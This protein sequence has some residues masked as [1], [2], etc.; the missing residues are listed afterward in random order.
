MPYNTLSSY[1]RWA[2]SIKEHPLFDSEE[3]WWVNYRI[4][5]KTMI[6]MNG[7]DIH[8]FWELL[9]VIRSSPQ[10]NTLQVCAI[11]VLQSE[12]ARMMKTLAGMKH[13]QD[14]SLYADWCNGRHDLDMVVSDIA[15]MDTPWTRLSLSP[16]LG[17]NGL[18]DFVKGLSQNETLRHLELKLDHF[19]VN[20]EE[21]AKGL[22]SLEKVLQKHPSLESTSLEFS[23]GRETPR[24][25][26]YLCDLMARNRRLTKVTVPLR[27]ITEAQLKSLCSSL[28]LPGKPVHHLVLQ[29]SD[30]LSFNYAF[31]IN[32]GLRGNLQIACLTLS[33]V[34]VTLEH[35]KVI[36][37]FLR[38]PVC[39]LSGLLL[40]NTLRAK[41][42]SLLMSIIL[43][44]AA[45]N[46]SLERL[47]IC[48]RLE[49]IEAFD[50][51]VEKP[52]SLLL[53]TNT[54]LKKLRIDLGWYLAYSLGSSFVQ[55]LR[56]N[57]TLSSLD[58]GGCGFKSNHSVCD[59]VDFL[60][61]HNVALRELC[62][63]PRTPE[64]FHGIQGGKILFHNLF[65]MQGLKRLTLRTDFHRS[66]LIHLTEPVAHVGM[67]FPN[68]MLRGCTINNGLRSYRAVSPILERNRCTREKQRTIGFQFWLYLR[69]RGNFRIPSDV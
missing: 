15:T 67:M 19:L 53:Q 21:G 51:L 24:S 54:M 28:H 33:R 59:L 9:E 6:R 48:D 58:L 63:H 35:A 29:E 32:Q 23:C 27:N 17:V 14:L 57:Q 64:D 50:E 52:L 45:H 37:D 62:V 41:D 16:F 44:A 39:H 1:G 3:Q 7:E 49:L 56:F 36:G 38:D 42:R 69:Q 46:Q 8:T 22:E 10:V 26:E 25:V 60:A 43:N 18:C 31:L 34:C 68:H 12:F 40:E 30:K 61:N 66:K 4:P 2:I 13:I 5:H 65:R 55:A 47:E 11:R 20:H